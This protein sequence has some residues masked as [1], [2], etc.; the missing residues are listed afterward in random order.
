MSEKTHTDHPSRHWD[1]TCPAC[2][3]EEPWNTSDMAHRSGGLTVD[4]TDLIQRAIDM[5]RT[6]CA[7][8]YRMIM[9]DAIRRATLREREACAK[10]C[11]SLGSE[12]CHDAIRGRTE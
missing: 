1:R 12:V 10:L 6:A 2:A 4:V 7:E 11:K 5:E 8:T 3:A 9:D